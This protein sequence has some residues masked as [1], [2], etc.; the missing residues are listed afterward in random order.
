LVFK[1]I[2]GFG[3]PEKIWSDCFRCSK[4]PIIG[5]EVA[6]IVANE[7]MFKPFPL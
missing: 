3:C 5:D 2:E 1:E 4:Y 6:M 7:I